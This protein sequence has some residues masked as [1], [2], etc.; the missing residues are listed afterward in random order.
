MGNFRRETSRDLR[1]LT[2]APAARS[3]R[4]PP[5]PAAKK[6]IPARF[7][8]R[9]PPRK[10]PHQICP[11]CTGSRGRKNRKSSALFHLPPPAFRQ[12]N[13]DRIARQNQPRPP[14]TE[15]PSPSPRLI[16]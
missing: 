3:G 6:S 16:V 15:S 8:V 11:H 10:P 9:V 12:P 1:S 4:F 14:P 13:G 5:L 7:F 2:A